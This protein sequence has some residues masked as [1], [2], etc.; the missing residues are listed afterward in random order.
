MRKASSSW[1]ITPNISLR[2]QVIKMKRAFLTC[3]AHLLDLKTKPHMVE[4]TK[5]SELAVIS[6]TIT[7][8][9]PRLQR[10]LKLEKE[11]DEM[12]KIIRNIRWQ[13]LPLVAI[14]VITSVLRDRE[15]IGLA[16]KATRAATTRAVRNL[17]VIPNLILRV[18]MIVVTE[19]AATEILIDTIGADKELNRQLHPKAIIARLTLRNNSRL[20]RRKS[21]E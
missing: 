7:T 17:L 15:S 16:R 18:S 2:E 13:L 8:S 19:T 11:L 10:F 6:E 12:V 3:L 20:H 4:P 14:M 1:K 9:I 5:V 21:K